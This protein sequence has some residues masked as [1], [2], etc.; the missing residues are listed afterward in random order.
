M[1]SCA[2]VQSGK[3]GDLSEPFWG[4]TTQYLG[5]NLRVSAHLM[6][7]CYPEVSVK[8]VPR[9]C[10]L[11]GE[12]APHSGTGVQGLT[13]RSLS[14]LPGRLRAGGVGLD[15]P[16]DLLEHTGK[17]SRDCSNFG[18]RG[19]ATHDIDTRTRGHGARGYGARRN[20]AGSSSATCGVTGGVR[21]WRH[22]GM[23]P[24]FF[25]GSVA[26]LVLSARSA[27]TTATR[28]AAGSMTPSSSP[29][30]AARKGDAT[31]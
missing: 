23:F 27:F 19:I 9:W 16:T 29:R 3:L 13:Q 24:C 11:P 12:A 21:V 6:R 14:A 28:V 18:R 26:R 15:V 7:R 5:A 30:S 1:L 31:L 20:G 10:E 25:G 8:S 22:S 2:G 4:K 17:Y